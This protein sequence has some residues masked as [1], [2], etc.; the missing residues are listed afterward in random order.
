VRAGRIIVEAGNEPLYI[1]L[2]TSRATIW[3]VTGAVERVERLVLSSAEHLGNSSDLQQPPLAGA[4]G[5]A[6][7][8]VSFLKR[9]N[10]LRYF[11]EVP[12]SQ[13]LLSGALIRQAAGKAP[14]VVSGKYGVSVF[15]VPSGRIDTMHDDRQEP[16]LIIEKREGK[17]TIIG[18]AGNVVI[19][20]GPSRARDE[21]NRFYPGGVSEIDPK[22]VVGSAPAEAYGTLPGQAGLVQLL[23]TGALTENRAGEYIVRKKIRF[24]AGLAGAQSVTFLVMKGTPYPDGDAG[25]SCVIVEESGESKGAA[26]PRR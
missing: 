9:V 11:S 5:L 21:M 17:L 26:C 23:A 15:S 19:Q 10:C 4:T 6:A 25:H 18:D 3:Q 13:S 2:T 8:R 20:T 1:V 24:P 12:S 7:E 14:D 16:R 22:A